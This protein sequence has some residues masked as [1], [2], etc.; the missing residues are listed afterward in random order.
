MN[1]MIDKVDLLPN[2]YVLHDSEWQ[3]LM[4]G[5]NAFG[6]Y[7][8]VSFLQENE[9]F[10][11]LNYFH[12]LANE[13]ILLAFLKGDV[14]YLDVMKKAD[15]IFLVR[16]SYNYTILNVEK[17]VFADLSKDMLPLKS[18]FFPK[19]IPSVFLDLEKR[20]SLHKTA[21]ERPKK[22]LAT[23]HSQQIPVFH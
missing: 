9:E 20:I 7:L 12:V 17:I 14:A 10:G 5:K 3:M 1:K 21:I 15:A 16:K 22:R 2:Y 13:A 6:D 18:S 4:L 19:T 11:Q 23:E 8:V